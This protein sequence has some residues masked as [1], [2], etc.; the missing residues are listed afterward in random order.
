MIGLMGYAQSG[1]D[2]TASVLVDEYGFTRIAFADALREM[3]YALNPLAGPPPGDDVGHI[4][5]QDLVNQLGWDNAK[6]QYAEIR[7]LLQRLGTEAGRTILGENVWVDAAMMKTDADPLGDFVFTDCRFPSEANAIR[8]SGGKLW[9]I[10]RDGFG[11]V[12]GH[13]SETA[14][15]AQ[16]ADVTIYNNWTL[17]DLRDAV[18]AEIAR[19]RRA[20]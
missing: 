9:R 20:A 15:D 14:L 19:V 16:R 6:M 12:N 1:K 8:A 5:V 2:T 3:L 7:E 17:N 13:A 11:P 4:R 10:E 18:R